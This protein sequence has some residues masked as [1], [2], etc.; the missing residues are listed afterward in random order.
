MNV[1]I[2]H[3]WAKAT[4]YYETKK[5]K[6]WASIIIIVYHIAV[7][8]A[9]GIYATGMSN[10]SKPST[11]ASG[12]TMAEAGILLLLVLLLLQ[13]AAF[14]I[15]MCTSTNQPLRPLLFAIVISLL[16]LKVCSPG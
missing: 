1:R 5:T 16:L 10:S 15:L 11:H 2:L 13:V 3:G 9:I 7:I 12:Q 8:T 4:G 14:I 6:R